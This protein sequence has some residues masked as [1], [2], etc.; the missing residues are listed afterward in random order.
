MFDGPDFTVG[1]PFGT[2]GKSL[3]LPPFPEPRRAAMEAELK[4][5]E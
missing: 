2:M 3:S 1:K 5:L 4:P